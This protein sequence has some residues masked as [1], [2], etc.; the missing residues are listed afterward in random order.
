MKINYFL[1]TAL[2]ITILL[3][4]QEQQVEI[5]D[6][7]PFSYVFMTFS[8]THYQIPEKIPVF[9]GEIRKQQ[10]QSK[11]S[12]DLFG[13]YFDFRGQVAGVDTVWG[14]GFKMSKD[15]TVQLPLKKAQ[16]NYEKIVRMIHVGPYEM[17][18][19][20]YNVMIAY[21]EENGMEIIG[22]PIET[23]LDAN[24]DQVEP[25]QHRTE[26]IIPVRKIKK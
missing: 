5:K 25:E 18:N 22:P 2:S 16:Y 20:A 12:G 13:I 1:L 21:L 10:L 3:N 4:A 11:I 6:G 7:T 19:L 9:I 24:P 14:L 8:G 26:I 15:T 17:V 23:W